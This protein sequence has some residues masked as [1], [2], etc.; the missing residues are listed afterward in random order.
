[1]ANLWVWNGPRAGSWSRNSITGK[2]EKPV[3]AGVSASFESV[4]V[5]D[6]QLFWEDQ[7]GGWIIAVHYTTTL[8]VHLSYFSIMASWR[9]TTTGVL[10]VLLRHNLFFYRHYRDYHA[11][12]PS[13]SCTVCCV[14]THIM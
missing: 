13:V 2:I 4:D 9:L 8:C 7:V 10:L 12:I 1:M 5:S 11:L 3:P 14:A 6:A